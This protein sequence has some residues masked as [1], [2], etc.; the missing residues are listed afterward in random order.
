M[1]SGRLQRIHQ[2]FI[3][4][5][6]CALVCTS[7]PVRAQSPGDPTNVLADALFRQG[8]ELLEQEKYAEACIKL[9][10]SQ[11]LDP[12][13]GTLLNL[14]HCHEKEG[15]IATA[16]AE[17]VTA[18]ALARQKNQHERESFA[19]ERIGELE[20]KLA[21]VIFRMEQTPAGLALLLDDKPIDAAALNTPMPIDPG[22]H[23]I[24]AKAPGKQPFHLEFDVAAKR[25]EIPLVIPNLQD[26]P[27]PPTPEMD[28]HSTSDPL[29]PPTLPPVQSSVNVL[30]GPTTRIAPTDQRDALARER[31]R[32]FIV[33]GFGI[34]GA[35]FVLGAA[36][37]LATIV[38]A[39]EILPN[40]QGTKCAAT[41]ADKLASANT[42][43]NVSNVG[44]VLAVIGVGGGIAGIVMLPKRKTPH[45]PVAI[46]PLVGPGTIGVRGVF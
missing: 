26:E 12:K 25:A 38:K 43:A 28:A 15:R 17:Y 45:V 5:L 22:K 11:R 6:Q 24:T 27:P 39:D 8:R 10:E 34:G 9:A 44:F 13:L 42:L 32:F 23:G 3:V 35:G 14:A 21:V 2:C 16:R 4:G 7:M 29:P 1:K 46:E 19:L 33:T 40:C 36:T 37:G 18:A 30:P 31:A 41:D 20:K